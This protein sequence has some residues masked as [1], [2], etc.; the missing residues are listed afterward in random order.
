[1]L[2]IHPSA[3]LLA[4]LLLGLSGSSYLADSAWAATAVPTHSVP[5]HNVP[6]KNAATG[7]ALPSVA[8]PTKAV[9]P[10]ATGETHSAIDS[11]TAKAALVAQGIADASYTLP[12][13]LKPLPEHPRTA[14]NVVDQLQTYHF[15][16]RP[17]DDAE[18][19]RTLDAYLKELDEEHAYFTAADIRDFDKYRTKLDDALRQGDL[20]PAYDIFNRYQLR[21]VERLKNLLA[22]LYRGLDKIDFNSNEVLEI[23][24]DKSPWAKNTAELDDLWKR[25]LKATVLPMVLHGKSMAE[26]QDLLIKRYH[27]RL[28]QTGK[29]VSEDAF[30]AFINAFAA[31]FD[32]HTQYFSPRV[33]ENFNITMSLQLEGIGAVL[34]TEDEYTTVVS[35]VPAGPADKAGQLKPTDHIIAVGQ[36]TSGPM[37]DVVGWRLDDVVEMVRGPTATVVRLEVAPARGDGPSKIIQIIRDKVQLEEQSAHKKLVTINDKGKQRRVGI[38]E[39]PTF[40]ADFEAMQRGD[41]DFKSTTRDVQKL[42]EELKVQGVDGLVIDLRNNGGGSLAEANLLTGLFI[43][44]GP[45]VQLRGGNRRVTIYSD[46]DGKVAWSGPLAVLV[47]RMSASASEIFAAAIQ[48]YQRGLIIGSTTFGKGTVQSLEGLGRG[49]LKYTQQKFYRISGQSTQHQG[50]KPDIRFPELYDTHLV[51][52]SALDDSLP[53]DTIR[54]AAHR[55]FTDF[56]ALLPA[57]SARH[58]TRSQEDPEFRYV[59][60]LAQR[61]AVE[62]DKKTVS[63]NLQT[64]KKEQVADDAWR[65]ALEN[66]LRRAKGQPL[67]ANVDQIPDDGDGVDGVNGGP[68]PLSS[69]TSQDSGNKSATSGNA[70][71]PSTATKTPEAIAAAKKKKEEEPDAMAKEAS[72]ILVDLL[73]TTRPAG[74]EIKRTAAAH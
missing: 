43:E 13:A 8:T 2:R 37:T 33:S 40:Y 61:A 63:L 71:K 58:A 46:D 54:P 74:P 50:V 49:Q 16:K 59:E 23:D 48:D 45:T 51:G 52:E 18:S 3:A 53:W 73:S 29:T 24:R 6:T 32:P 31:T 42:I 60:T 62:R 68:P 41:P 64:R 9:A 57:L 70:A 14:R 55:R 19:S 47:N 26:V 21:V 30:Q 38:I 27:N 7:P 56:T 44:S 72:K 4:A 25:R 11:A 1:M 15:I 5:S 20:A 69:V 35:L 10:K 39:V 65:L 17:L 22:V 12:P 66:N 67:L 28:L 36:G 34:R